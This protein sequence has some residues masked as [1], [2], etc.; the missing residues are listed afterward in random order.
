MAPR[1]KSHKKRNRWEGD[2]RRE[3]PSAS[4]KRR[5]PVGK[6]SPPERSKGQGNPSAR[7]E[8]SRAD[9]NRIFGEFIADES[10]RKER[11]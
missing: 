9:M 10:K 8:L 3:K 2:K 6:L 4:G 11:K 1:K 7:G 5:D